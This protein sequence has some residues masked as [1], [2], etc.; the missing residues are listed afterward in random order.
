MF[1][2]T[3]FLGRRIV[4]RLADHG[5]FVRIASRHPAQGGASIAAPEAV[6][7]VYADVNDDRSVA[8]AVAGMEAVVN[9]VSLYMERGA[10]TFRSVHVEAAERVA[11]RARSAG[12]KRLILVSGIGADEHSRS[13]YIRSRGQGEAMVRSAFPGATI[14]RPAVMFGPDDAFLV[15]LA[16][17]LRRLPAFALFGRGGTR[18]QPVYVEDVA[19]AAV[20]ILQTAEPQAVYEL[21]GPQV[22]TYADLLQLIGSRAGVRRL[23]VPIPFSAWHGLAR[24]A[25][26]LPRPPLTRNQI[27]LM[28]IDNVAASGAAGLASLHITPRS[29]EEVLPEI[30]QM[31]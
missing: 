10:Q 20:R 15:T 14:M 22:Y 16:T 24:I 7:P 25:E 23:L 19:E 6:A 9:A 1:G 29:I 4:R 17:L 18:L 11:R 27:E 28:E 3:G 5:F 21:G 12:V 8:D 31:A 13:P 30:L 26:L 2:G